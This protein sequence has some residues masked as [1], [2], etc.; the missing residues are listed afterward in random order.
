MV[1]SYL[2]NGS[3]NN[4]LSFSI[5]FPLCC[6]TICQHIKG[7]VQS[8]NSLHSHIYLYMVV[9]IAQVKFCIEKTSVFDYYNEV[10]YVE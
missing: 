10:N 5:V 8:Y 2:F 4:I 9:M 7:S 3:G 1:N 6:L